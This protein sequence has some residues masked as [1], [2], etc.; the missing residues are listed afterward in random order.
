MTDQATGDSSP[1]TTS[2]GPQAPPSDQ[3]STTG[4][5]AP[6]APKRKPILPRQPPLKL[7][8][9]AWLGVSF[10]PWVAYWILA[11]LLPGWWWF[12]TLV[13]M[14]AGLLLLGYRFLYLKV[15]WWD[16]ATPIYFAVIFILCTF[17]QAGRLGLFIPFG[18]ALSYIVL[19]GLWLTTLLRPKPLTLAYAT[20]TEDQDVTD[21]TR[22]LHGVTTAVW[23][24]VFL[25]SAVLCLAANIPGH[26]VAW[27]LVRYL[28]L[29]MAAVFTIVYLNWYP[30]V[31]AGRKKRD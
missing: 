16:L 12:N 28:V 4:K 3:P 8:G 30:Q 14:F 5:P 19:A 27:T 6:A 20:S 21:L 1:E 23:A 13:A 18:S 9:L 29:L 15:T 24:L 17:G 11:G 31:A 10:G 26:A 2:S 22:R 25:L 7:P